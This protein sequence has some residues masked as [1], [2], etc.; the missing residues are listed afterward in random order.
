MN[1]AFRHMFLCS[2]ELIG[3]PVS[4]LMDP[5]PFEKVG[6]GAVPQFNA[7]TRHEKYGLVCRQIIYPLPQE[8]QVACILVSLEDSR[9]AAAK[10]EH[11]RSTTL[12]QAQQ[13]LEHQIS[14][15]QEIAKYLGE[16]TA[17]GEELVRKIIEL[18]ETDD[19][20]G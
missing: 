3:R 20:A 12:A 16:S 7:V 11:L 14:M 9:S 17:H 15:A 1:P 2:D 4:Y 18:S 10:V 19:Q 13:L 8:G 5:E 6:S